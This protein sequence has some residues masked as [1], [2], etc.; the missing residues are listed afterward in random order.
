MSDY[1]AFNNT[2]TGPILANQNY[3]S[4][5]VA[6]GK[7]FMKDIPMGGSRRNSQDKMHAQQQPATG[8]LHNNSLI[9]NNSIMTTGNGY[10][11]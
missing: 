7:M 2:A 9:H 6:G 3:G 4:K 8:V 11:P 10:V 1:Q 5:K